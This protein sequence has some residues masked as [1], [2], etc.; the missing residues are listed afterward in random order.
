MPQK[1]IDC[2]ISTIF[3]YPSCFH[4]LI[5]AIIVTLNGTFLS[6]ITKISE[7]KDFSF[8]DFTFLS[9]FLLFYHWFFNWETLTLYVVQ[10]DRS[11]ENYLQHLQKC[12]N[13]LGVFSTHV[14]DVPDLFRLQARRSICLP[15]KVGFQPILISTKWQ[16]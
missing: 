2:Q 16:K 15:L 12:S 11:H 1:E 5:L 4:Q 7:R 6:P 8:T 14:L 3:F 10:G 9:L 13:P